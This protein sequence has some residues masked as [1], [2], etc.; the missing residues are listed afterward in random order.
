[1][2]FNTGEY[3]SQDLMAAM[4]TVLK[5]LYR[6]PIPADEQWAYKK[7]IIDKYYEEQKEIAE[8]PQPK[9]APW[10]TVPVPTLALA[11]VDS[12]ASKRARRRDRHR[13]TK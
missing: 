6:D 7:K 4:E 9:P 10:P 13:K 1:M 3:Q 8:N 11:P 5:I 12:A 2:T